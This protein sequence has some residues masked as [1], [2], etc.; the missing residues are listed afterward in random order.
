M[1]EDEEEKRVDLSFGATSS[2]HS[3]TSVT[4]RITVEDVSTC[5]RYRIS[6]LLIKYS[7]TPY[8]VITKQ[9]DLSQLDIRDSIRS[10]SLRST[11]SVRSTASQHSNDDSDSISTQSGSI[12]THHHS[13][14]EVTRH[15]LGYNDL[16]RTLDSTKLCHRHR[17]LKTMANMD[18]HHQMLLF[19]INQLENITLAHAVQHDLDRMQ[20]QIQVLDHY[21]YQL[22]LFNR[23]F[24]AVK[25]THRQLEFA[26]PR[27]FLVLPHELEHWDE[28]DPATH[29]FRLY[30]LCEFN[31]CD[32]S[33]RHPQSASS[34]VSPQH[35]HLVD[36]RGYDLERAPEFFALYGAY[37]LTMLELVQ[38][39]FADDIYSV[40]HLE[41]FQILDSPDMT[42]PLTRHNLTHTTFRPL[43]HHAIA[44]LR[45]LLPAS[46]R[47]QL[48]TSWL[49]VSDTRAVRSFLSLGG[50]SVHSHLDHGMGGLCRMTHRSDALW[51]CQSHAHPDHTRVFQFREFV[52]RHR[53]VSDLQLGWLSLRISSVVQAQELVVALKQAPCCVHDVAIR[54]E[55][56]PASRQDLARFLED[57]AESGVRVLQLD[58]VTRRVH[59]PE[60]IWHED[61]FLRAVTHTGL[62]LVTLLNYPYVGVQSM[63]LKPLKGR[64]RLMAEMAP[65]H[66]TITSTA[67]MTTR[68]DIAWE[69]LFVDL[70]LFEQHVL[71]ANTTT[72]SSSPPMTPHEFSDLL[73]TLSHRLR[74]HH[75]TSL[76]AI[77]VFDEDTLAWQGRLGVHHGLV[78]GITETF[79]GN[80]F[81]HPEILGYG[82]LRRMVVT[83]RDPDVVVP[84]MYTLMER[85]KGLEMIEMALPKQTLFRRVQEVCAQWHMEETLVM[86]VLDAL[87]DQGDQELVAVV[88]KGNKNNND[89]DKDV[90][91]HPVVTEVL[92]WN[93]DHVPLVV[94][95]AD[96]T[97]LELAS[98]NFPEVMTS[99]T[100]DVSGM[101]AQGLDCMQRVLQQSS[102]LE[103]LH[104]RCCAILHEYKSRIGQV[105]RAVQWSTIKALAL[106]G[107][108][109]NTW[110]DLWSHDGD[111]FGTTTGQGLK[112]LS[113]E[114]KGASAQDHYHHQA[115]SHASALAIHR[116]VYKCPLLVVL[117]LDQFVLPSDRDWDLILSAVDVAVLVTLGLPDGNPH[118]QGLLDQVARQWEAAGLMWSKV[119]EE[120]EEE[121]VD[122]AWEMLK[123]EG[124][125]LVEATEKRQRKLSQGCKQM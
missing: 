106:S 63:Y 102:S 17:F 111:L 99:F 78:Q 50:A 11:G 7:E 10:Y 44:Y 75:A 107:S 31:Y 121:E 34:T 116:L 12:I 1:E 120:E 103:M 6:P 110:I 60:R 45:Q 39:G 14:P 16:H 82:T 22:D 52:Q 73:D 109:I 94:K 69:K 86:N 23:S 38:Q 92:H 2:A 96:M 18:H 100:L 65:A 124:S 77:D 71:M 35:I 56:S 108:H 61:M 53:G 91:G 119:V 57:V 122:G 21:A 19:R 30:F 117:W 70:H 58:R 64:Y 46:G 37:A 59:P 123:G 113:L 118:C 90:G 49:S 87:E 33:S 3:P 68:P 42:P 28:H 40:P 76:T 97:L 83:A 24:V 20:N 112:L 32:A 79:I 4:S 5:Y 54:L 8:L 62:E 80:E 72:T 98:R 93:C 81:F 105:L 41:S 25:S 104:M 115:L 13:I 43:V 125:G 66:S 89:R 114:I 27:L 9:D 55:R 29:R 15:Y 85:N 101:T 88:V 51:L 84:S 67:M 36:H 95:D 26:G 48:W 47:R 74:L